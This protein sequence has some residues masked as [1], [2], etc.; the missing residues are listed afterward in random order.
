MDLCSPPPWVPSTVEKFAQTPTYC[1]GGKKEQA[2]PLQRGGL[3]RSGS[4]AQGTSFKSSDTSYG[5]SS[6]IPRIC[7]ESLS[8]SSRVAHSTLIVMRF[9]VEAWTSTFLPARPQTD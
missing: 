9:P 5:A 8:P 4:F 7:F 2:H 1:Q 6:R 3:D